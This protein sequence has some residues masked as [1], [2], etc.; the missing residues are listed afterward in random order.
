MPDVA[1]LLGLSLGG[2]SLLG[3]VS[4]ILY[5]WSKG[6]CASHIRVGDTELKIDVN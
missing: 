3:L 4:Y 1:S 5:S 6:N 2:T